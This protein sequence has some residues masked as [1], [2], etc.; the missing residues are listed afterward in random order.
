MNIHKAVDEGQFRQDLL[1]R[2]NTIELHIP[3]LRER[4]TDIPLLANHFASLYANKYSKVIQGFSAELLKRMREYPWPGNVRELQ[5]MV[6]RAVILAKKPTLGVDDFPL[7]GRY[8]KKVADSV[9]TLD[10]DTIEKHTIERAL[11]KCDGNVSRA[12][13]L[14]GITRFV[15]YRK[16]ERLG[17]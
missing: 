1:Y 16:M 14:L 6:E 13:R 9:E 12:A 8:N 2:I 15:L 4:I 17:L 11:S 3:P 5:H 10:L 7:N